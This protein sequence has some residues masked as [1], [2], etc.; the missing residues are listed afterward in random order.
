MCESA[1]KKNQGLSLIELLVSIAILALAMSGVIGLINLASRYY[2][3]S[4]K[5]VE[6]QSNLQ[7]S[8]A[9]VSNLMVDADCGVSFSGNVL[10]IAASGK[11]YLVAFTD[12]KL[13]LNEVAYAASD[14][15]KAKK[16][17]K[18]KNA[19]T[20][21][22]DEN[23]VL[24]D[25]VDTFFVDASNYEAGY[26]KMGMTVTYGSRTATMSKNV[27]LRNSEN[28]FMNLVSRSDAQA[29]VAT[30]SSG[31]K[32]YPKITFTITHSIPG[33]DSSTPGIAGGK[34][35]FMTIRLAV[36]AGTVSK[37][38]IKVVAAD[39]TCITKID[40]STPISVESYNPT[41]GEL[42]IRGKSVDWAASTD[43]AQNSKTLAITIEVDKAKVNKDKSFITGFGFRE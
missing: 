2:S 8:F 20:S 29:S 4:S 35:F 5:E 24:A 26:I 7:S 38:N 6:I 28:T 25:H 27:F 34:E 23:D 32:E 12:N 41:T 39:S 42:L 22:S 11:G 15:T 21:T 10:R 30:V 37:S 36:T 3:N 13:Y 16:W 18:V 19:A 31:G 14:N 33:P 9:V 40:D 17:A 43:S 1:V